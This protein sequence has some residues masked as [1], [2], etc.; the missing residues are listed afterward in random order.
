MIKQFLIFLALIFFLKIPFGVNANIEVQSS[1]GELSSQTAT[2]FYIGLEGFYRQDLAYFAGFVLA[3]PNN[4]SLSLQTSRQEFLIL[5]RFLPTSHDEYALDTS[6]SAQQVQTSIEYYFSQRNIDIHVSFDASQTTMIVSHAGFA[7]GSLLSTLFIFLVLSLFLGLLYIRRTIISRSLQHLARK[8][9]VDAWLTTYQKASFKPYLLKRK[10]QSR[11]ANFKRIQKES[12][13][14]AEQAKIY[15]DAGEFNTAKILVT[16]ASHLNIANE[17]ANQLITDIQKEEQS[18][19]EVSETEQWLRNKVAKAMN[20]YQNN[21]P[22]K[23]LRQ[24]YQAIDKIGSQK[25]FKKQSK[26]LKKLTLKILNENSNAI[27]GVLINCSQSLKSVAVCATQTV[28]LGRLPHKSDLPWISVQDSVFFINNKKVSRI[29]Q[30]AQITRLDQKFWLS[31]VGSKNG[32]YINANKC[33]TNT[34]VPIKNKDSITLASKDAVTA[35]TYKASVSICNELVLLK[36]ISAPEKLINEKEMANIWPDR[37]IALHKQLACVS[38][39]FVLLQRQNKKDFKLLSLSDFDELDDD[40]NHQSRAL[41]V[42][43][44]GKKAKISPIGADD[45]LI[46]GSSL[47]GPLPLNLPCEVSVDKFV[48]HLSEYKSGGSYGLQ[49]SASEALISD[50]KLR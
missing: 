45:V 30:H 23:A 38:D 28:H 37:Q 10:W 17:L 7:Y 12:L 27:S 2:T 34:A 35:V 4:K 44:L 18:A 24:L 15:F 25:G 36:P 13:E 32:T 50:K 21:N 40:N 3:N 22:V 49:T 20:N 39:K 5:D 29:G 14:L 6:L 42:I 8:R 41:C 33:T 26:A 47:V 46:D 9:D 31:D 11:A 48:L 1:V 43:H 19:N 16:K